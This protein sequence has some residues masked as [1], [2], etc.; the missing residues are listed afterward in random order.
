MKKYAIVTDSA[1]GLA[2]SFIDEHD[3][4]VLPMS[5]I[6]EGIAYKEGLDKSVAE[7]YELLKESGEGAKTS[8]PTIGEFMEIFNEI[9]ENDEYDS[10]ISIHASSELTGTYQSALSV[11]EEIEKPVTVIDSKIGSYPMGQMVARAVEGRRNGESLEEVE[12]EINEIISNSQ[13]YL[14]PHSFSQLKKSGRVSASQSMLASLLKVQ[15][16]L[17][18]EDGK[19]VVGHKV[20]TKKKMVSHMLQV[21][22]DHMK[23]D[24]LE[25]L[26]IVYA[27]GRSL[28][29]E[30]EKTVRDALP[31]LKLVFE[32]LVTVAGVHVG[33]GTIA[34]GLIK[35]R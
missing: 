21:L 18:F 22:E 7:I 26:A 24:G 8:Q 1:A 17:R 30:W 9:E 5:V 11:S 20:R 13:L 15:L 35:G 25:T 16:Q 34:F 33:H 10:I 12:A 3:I 2:Q 4:K 23:R 14:L 29:D 6:V 32:P 31:D 27:G 19:V 28:A